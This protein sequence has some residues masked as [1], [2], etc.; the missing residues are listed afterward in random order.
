MA[1]EMTEEL[2]AVEQVY[3]RLIVRFRDACQEMPGEPL[4]RN[5]KAYRYDLAIGV[6][7][8]CWPEE[9]ARWKAR[10]AKSESK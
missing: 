4:M 2:T 5:V 1:R 8:E 9:T 10:F 7:E 6:L 3:S